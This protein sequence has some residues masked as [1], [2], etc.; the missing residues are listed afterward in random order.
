MRVVEEDCTRGQ[1]EER[2]NA[3]MHCLSSRPSPDLQGFSQT[4]CPALT[5]AANGYQPRSRFP[6]GTPAQYQTNGPE[7]A[8]F[9]TVISRHNRGLSGMLA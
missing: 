7:L 9:H 8:T 5:V 1:L 3:W 4:Y 2:R 6:V